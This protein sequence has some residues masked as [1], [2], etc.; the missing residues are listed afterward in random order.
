MVELLSEVFIKEQHDAGIDLVMIVK[1]LPKHFIYRKGLK[2]VQRVDRDGY[3][4]GTL[5]P[6]PSGEKVDELLDGLEKSQTDDGSI[7]FTQR[8]SAKQA[9]EAIDQFIQGTLPRDILV[10]KR[11]PYP[12]DSTDTRSQ[13][14]SKSLIPVVELPGF[15]AEVPQVS[16]EAQA[17]PEVSA[18]LK[19]RKP[20]TEQQRIAAKERLARAREIRKQQLETE[21]NV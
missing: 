20:L 1:N 21:K 12:L 10:P 19:T 8:E 15:K 18:P 6:D 11:V 4:D 5:V 2:M 9:L 17:S 13:P 16:P 3:T 7:V 14:R